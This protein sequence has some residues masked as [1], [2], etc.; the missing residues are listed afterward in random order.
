MIE[1]EKLEEIKEALSATRIHLQGNQIVT[2]AFVIGCC[3]Q[4]L[5]DIIDEEDAGNPAD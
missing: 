2:A 3:H 1:I 5:E 4:M